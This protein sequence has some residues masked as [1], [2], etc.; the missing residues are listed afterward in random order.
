MTGRKL[1]CDKWEVVAP[2]RMAHN[3]EKERAIQSTRLYKTSASLLSSPTLL[4]SSRRVVAFS[5]DAMTYFASLL[6]LFS[7]LALHSPLP[8]NAQTE[9][10]TISGL[11]TDEGGGVVPNCEIV[12]QSVA[13]GTVTTVRTNDTGIYVFA[14]VQPG[15]YNV[16][17]KRSGFRQV[18]L[19]NLIV[20]VQ[21]HIEQNI[22]LRV[23]SVSESVTVEANR[24]NINTT[25]ASVSTVVD[26]Q[27]VENMPLNGR[28]FQNLIALSPG[29]VL[30]PGDSQE[31]GQFSFNG[32]RPSANYFMVD[33]VSAN[34][35]VSFAGG[36]NQKDAGTTAGFTVTGGTNGL[37]SVDEM[38]EFRI[39]TSTYAPEFG[40]TPG[41]QISIVTRSGTNQLHGSL[42]NY[43]RNDLL[44]AND[45]FANRSGLRKPAERQNDFGGVFGGPIRR[46]RTFFF[47]SYEGLRLRLP[48]TGTTLVPG[49]AARASAPTAIQPFLN[50]YPK[51]TGPDNPNGTAPFVAGFSDPS[52]LDAVGTRFDQVASS[53]LRL[54]GRYRHASS[55]FGDRG[56]GGIGGNSAL[57]TATVTGSVMDTVTVGITWMIT[58]VMFND[59]RFNYSQN[60]GKS[61]VVFDNFGGAGDAPPDSA[62]FPS[63]FTS[64]NS[65]FS[66][67]ILGLG[68]NS[69]LTFG[70]L[71]D[72]RQRQINVLESMSRNQGHHS[73]KFGVDW[74]HLFPEQHPVTYSEQI[75]F[76]SVASAVALA[77]S[78]TFV[79]HRVPAT[80]AFNN[81]GSYVQD[82][83]TI[84]PGVTLT[85]GL[86]WDIDFAPHATEKPD[87]LAFTQTDNLPTT[88]IA[89]VGTPI[90]STTY[91]NFAPRVGIAYQLRQT[92]DWS[93]VLRGG[94]GVFYD[95]V[96]GQASQGIQN[97]YP[98]GAGRS[99]P[100]PSIPACGAGPLT[101][102]VSQAVV[103][104]PPIVPAFKTTLAVGIDPRIKLPYS[105]QWNL[106]LEQALGQNQALSATWVGQAGRRL[107]QQAEFFPS[108]NPNF[109]GFDVFRNSSTS[110]YNSL[111]LQYRRRVTRGLQAIASYTLSHSIDTAS[112]NILTSSLFVTN[113]N[114]R[115]PSDFDIRHTLAAALTYNVPSPRANHALRAII[116]EW[117]LDNLI[118]ARSSQPVNVLSVSVFNLV[119]GN[120]GPAR[121]NVVA[122][123]PLYVTDSTVGGGRRINRAAFVAAPAGQQ[124]SLGRN[125]LRGFNAAQWDLAIR[126]EFRLKEGLRLQFR[127]EFFN[128]LN[129]P[130]FA[131]PRNQLI[132]PLFGTSQQTLARQLGGTSLSG[133]FSPLYQIGGPRSIQFALKLQF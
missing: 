2:G 102:P 23:G 62:L 107:L 55:D 110:D 132:D 97:I 20:N 25:D 81:L 61:S 41:A 37:V 125:A 32:Q 83:W 117:S 46:N 114:D 10:A 106:S 113:S 31:P 13:R 17:V 38:E 47:L 131:P 29:T 129:H 45:W 57:N 6:L 130:S 56:S 26:R 30:T 133:G 72:N 40:R 109:V 33:G 96:S 73:L 34:I 50:A 78:S 119:N 53:R 100:N 93:T 69:A 65:R 70:N 3:E 67:L 116:G 112:S 111:Q 90:Y 124:G 52:S 94:F 71:A 24:L 1:S 99:C 105:L 86:R 115:G 19:L 54:F 66:F 48:V 4:R 27:F 8:L 49:N 91:G 5:F 63:G 79:V 120:F 118:Q 43:F 22:R 95:L 84:H 64:S 9:T 68:R 76:A 7:L 15:Q 88:A 74:R 35:G 59:L 123:V 36:P 42:F 80:V 104:P 21:D 11:I 92:N 121:P 82:T 108:P 28:S 18:D 127:S 39:Q 75:N 60:E 16:T 58:P 12:L 128:I 89:P 44:D 101:F 122:N 14:N 77:P 85:Y 103:A 87:L 51:P 98:F 126:R